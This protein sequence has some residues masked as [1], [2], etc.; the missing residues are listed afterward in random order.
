MAPVDGSILDVTS[1]SERA[2]LAGM[3]LLRIGELTDLELV[4][5]L[6]SSDVITIST[7]TTAYVERW[8]GDTTLMA[9][10]TRIEPSAF[11][12][13]SALGI[14]EQRVR[15]VLDLT[16][17]PAEFAGLGDGFRVFIR[18]VEW[19]SDAALQIPISALFREG[20]DWKVFR[21]TDNIAK[22]VTV[23]IGPRT[24]F[25]AEV[26]S[27]LSEED[28]VI[29]HPGDLVSEGVEIILRDAL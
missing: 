16:S 27:G 9:Q 26:L 5:D 20:D 18:V 6:L 3:P 4:V 14:T 13:I 8:G 1:P 12:K 24:D 7:G 21:V 25:M 22:T 23:E 19:H 15:V 2:V 11:T 29:T 10:I 28:I 17:P